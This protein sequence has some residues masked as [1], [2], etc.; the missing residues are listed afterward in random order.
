MITPVCLT[1]WSKV[2]HCA[3]WNKQYDQS[4]FLV[5]FIHF[6]SPQDFGFVVSSFHGQNKITSKFNF[7]MNNGNAFACILQVFR[8]NTQHHYDIIVNANF[9]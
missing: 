8:N 6:V 4:E 9:V 3:C 5:N 2:F 1:V 7:I